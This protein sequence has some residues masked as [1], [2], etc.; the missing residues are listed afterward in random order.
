MLYYK[1]FINIASIFAPFLANIYP[2]WELVCLFLLRLGW[3][4]FVGVGEIFFKRVIA[5]FVMLL[6]NAALI[7]L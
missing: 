2:T 5:H 4:I 1:Y 7:R 3:L 6:Y